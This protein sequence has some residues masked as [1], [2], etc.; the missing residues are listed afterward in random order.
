MKL[1]FRSTQKFD[2]GHLPPFL[3]RVID[4]AKKLPDGDLVDAYQLSIDL[5]THIGSVRQF[6]LHPA[7]Q[8]YKFMHKKKAWYGNART[9][10]AAK[11]H[12]PE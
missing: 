9:I 4:Y 7:I 12:P 8:D 10:K 6:A 1:N 11:S 5:H 2:P 3:H